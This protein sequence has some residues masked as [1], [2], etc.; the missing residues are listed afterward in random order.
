MTRALKTL[1]TCRGSLDK[2]KYKLVEKEW[3]QTC[4]QLQAESNGLANDSDSDGVS[5]QEE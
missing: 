4:E 3:Q 5:G 1:K 2:S